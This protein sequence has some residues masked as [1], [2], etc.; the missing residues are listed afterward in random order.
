M[1]Q[2]WAVII[3]QLIVSLYLTYKVFKLKVSVDD[4][5]LVIGYI[6]VKTGLDQEAKQDL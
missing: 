5:Y 3:I 4:A 6:L 1:T 2:L